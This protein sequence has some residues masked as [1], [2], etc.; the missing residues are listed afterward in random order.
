MF[1][2][3]SEDHAA[4]MFIPHGIVLRHEAPLR[5]KI[6]VLWNMTRCC[7]VDVSA[8]RVPISSGSWRFGRQTEDGGSIFLRLR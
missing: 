6:T 7:L 5:L 1:T 8:K 3:V 4:S 2:D